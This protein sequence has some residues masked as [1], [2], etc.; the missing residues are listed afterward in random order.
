MEIHTLRQDWQNQVEAYN[1]AIALL[2]REPLNG[3][4]NDDLS[5]SGRQW[6]HLLVTWRDEFKSLLAEYPA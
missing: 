1:A 5:Q 3:V 6:P 2:D 4:T